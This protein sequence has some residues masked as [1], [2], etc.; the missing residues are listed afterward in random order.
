MLPARFQEKKD[1]ISQLNKIIIPSIP[2]VKS[3]EYR[4]Y[5]ENNEWSFYPE[6]LEF[7]ILT[8][9]GDTEIARFCS[10]IPTNQLLTLIEP[11]LRSSTSSFG[12][13]E[14]E[15]YKSV[16]NSERYVR[17]DVEEKKEEDKKDV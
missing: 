7:L 1:F 13:N 16:K 17:K 10:G 2:Q 9:E 6:Y 4:V 15:Y 3:L 14:N 8:Y 5:Q 12:S 11:H